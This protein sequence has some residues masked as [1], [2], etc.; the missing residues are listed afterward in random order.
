[1]HAKTRYT[2][3]MTSHTPLPPD[4]EQFVRQQLAAGRFASEDEVIFAALHLL[5][6][7]GTPPWPAGSRPPQATDTLLRSQPS[8]SVAEPSRVLDELG[9]RAAASVA[10]RRSPRG[11][12]ADLRSGIS[13]DEIKVARSEMW[14]GF[15]DRGAG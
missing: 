14:S 9:A 3:P 2:R 13:F 15:L 6:Q 12:L 10:G 1:M 7:H 8:R 5:E 11:I 4:L